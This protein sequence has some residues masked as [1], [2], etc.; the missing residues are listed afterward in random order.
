MAFYFNLG[1]HT[2]GQ[3]YCSGYIGKPFIDKSKTAL[4]VYVEVSIIYVCK[5]HNYD[6]HMT[7]VL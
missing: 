7:N 5:V 3:S 1:M 6:K 2:F 4:S